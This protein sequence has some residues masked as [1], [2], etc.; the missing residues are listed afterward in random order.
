MPD[1]SYQELMKMQNDAIRRVE[2]MQKRARRSAGIPEID[3]SQNNASGN[4]TNNTENNIKIAK[5]PPRRVPMPNTYLDNLKKLAAESAVSENNINRTYETHTESNAAAVQ[6]ISQ[7]ENTAPQNAASQNI[8]TSQNLKNMATELTADSDKALL[9]SL[10][11]LLSEE[12]ADETLLL[13]LI[14][15]MT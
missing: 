7:S 3:T 10:I 8:S 13:A 9:L 4:I 14:Y 11:L 1:Y 2:D 12:Q 6:N 15:M 5:E